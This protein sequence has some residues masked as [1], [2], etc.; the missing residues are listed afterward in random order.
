[1]KQVPKLNATLVIIPHDGGTN[2][3]NPYDQLAPEERHQKIVQL[4]ARIYLRMRSRQSAPA[5]AE[6]ALTSSG[7]PEPAASYPRF[8]LAGEAASP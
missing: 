2:P 1:M 4:C 6:P 7:T 8:E 3:R 5:T